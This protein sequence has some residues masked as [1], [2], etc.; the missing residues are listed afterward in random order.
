MKNCSV[1]QIMMQKLEYNIFK[2]LSWT[3]LH[4]IFMRSSK[5]V[6]GHILG[7]PDDKNKDGKHG[8]SEK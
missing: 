3:G 7:K 1:Q 4:R 8:N 6:G 5:S 2:I